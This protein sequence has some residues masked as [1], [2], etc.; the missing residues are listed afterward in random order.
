MILYAVVYVVGDTN[1][2]STRAATNNVGTHLHLDQN[3]FEAATPTRKGSFLFTFIPILSGLALSFLYPF[4]V[5][6]LFV[7]GTVMTRLL[8]ALLLHP[9]LY[10]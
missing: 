5:I 6:P 10:C 7:G 3:T 8:I 2:R 1:G 4:L 9:L